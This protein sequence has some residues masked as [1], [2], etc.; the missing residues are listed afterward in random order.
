[1]RNSLASSAFLRG[2]VTGREI[3]YDIAPKP[4]CMNPNGLTHRRSPTTSGV[5][6]SAVDSSLAKR[7][8]FKDNKQKEII[9]KVTI[10][11]IYFLRSCLAGD[12]SPTYFIGPCPF[13][14]FPDPPHHLPKFFLG[15]DS[16]LQYHR[17]IV[18]QYSR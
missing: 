6:R 8:P 11:F 14:S 3:T 7:S 16:W 18:C 15:V 2:R 1:M 9:K 17:G 5:E 10:L 12:H 13:S 4:T